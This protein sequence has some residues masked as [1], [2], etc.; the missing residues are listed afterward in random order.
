MIQRVVEQAKKA[1]SLS[2]VIVATDNQQIF[3][4]I[5][6]F[7]GE[8]SMTSLTHE[9]GTSR[10]AE[11]L[12]MFAISQPSERY[13]A[14]INIQGDEPFI[15]PHQ[16]DVVASLFSN[17]Q[18]RIG[19]LIKLIN[20]EDELFN[21]NVVKVVI[22]TKKNALFF[23]RQVIPFTRDFPQN[24]WLE[25]GQYFKHIGIY[26][27]RSDILNELVKLKLGK[28]EMAE[29]LEQLRWLENGYDISVEIIDYEGVSIDTPE[30]LLKLTNKT[31]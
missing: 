7:G 11:V 16:I 2:K 23:S 30:D 25:R 9:N 4:H 21:Q 24:E 22:N 13:D 8:V 31:C 5:K 27:Y 17:H 19:T 29:K 28:L 6:Q 18:T 12:K 15:D 1:G 14:V 3:D 10:C 26:G 20:S